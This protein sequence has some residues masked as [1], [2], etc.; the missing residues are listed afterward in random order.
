MK[1]WAVVG[2][3]SV[4][5]VLFVGCSP[6]SRHKVLNIFFDG[7]PPP[8]VAGAAEGKPAAGAGGAMGSRAVG[9]REHGPYAARLCN[10]CH[11]SAATNALLAPTEEL[12]FRCHEFR[13]IRKNVH[14][15]LASGGC[16]VCHDPHS[17]RY[18]NLLVSESDN[19][20]VHCH[21]QTAIEKT[22]AHEGVGGK[23]TA[24]HDS[25]MSDKA[26]LLK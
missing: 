7:V 14:G 6:A 15:P 9:Y 13:L 22:S 24:C 19:F 20:C 11:E 4:V 1:L 10:A 17:S 12:C 26:Y 18:E 2:C 16:L 23:C 21:E 5:A 8:K 3:T 25:H